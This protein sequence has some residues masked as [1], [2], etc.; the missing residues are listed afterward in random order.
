MDRVCMR[1]AHSPEPSGEAPGRLVPGLTDPVRGLPN[2]EGIDEEVWVLNEEGMV[3]GLAGDDPAEVKVLQVGVPF[4]SALKD[5]VYCGG[6]LDM[7]GEV[8]GDA[9]V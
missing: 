8:P 5:P 2:D 7:P 9:E 4:L 1:R 6:D 3:V